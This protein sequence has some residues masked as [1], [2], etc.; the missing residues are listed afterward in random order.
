MKIGTTTRPT[1]TSQVRSKQASAAAAGGTT[2]S[3][4]PVDET[5]LMGIPDAELTPKVREALFSLLSEVQKLRT[6]LSQMKGR[7]AD[8][9]ELADR[10]PLV[11]IFNR[12][13]FVRELDRTL[14]M[15]TRYDIE[16]CLVFI[17]LNDLKIINDERGHKAG[18]E[19]LQ[20]VAYSIAEN[21][22]QSD[23]VGRLGG[24]EFGL[25][26]T[27]VDVATAQSKAAA[28]SEVIADA[29]IEG[30]GDPF[31]VSISCGVVSIAKG[32]TAD[33]AMESADI[34][35]YEAKRRK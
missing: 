2:V 26:L 11:D 17:D 28:L 31:S 9:E 34:A 18:D 23:I 4:T 8:L 32:A 30:H 15:V 13:A 20:H 16:A 27:H 24:D 1:A 33:Q 14:A 29:V 21:I 22:R 3:T 25:L 7:M 19:A 12:R 6:E 5:V 35:M 10:D